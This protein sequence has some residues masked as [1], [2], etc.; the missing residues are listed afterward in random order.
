MGAYIDFNNH[1]HISM[2][3]NG[4]GVLRYIGYEDIDDEFIQTLSANKKVRWVQISEYLPDEAYSA[5]DRIFE[6]RPDMTFRLFHF[7]DCEKLDI[8]FLLTMPHMHRLQID[9]ITGLR[10]NP[11]KI[12][13]NILEKL[14]LKSLSLNC[15]GLRDYYFIKNLSEGLEELTIYADVPSG[16]IKYDNEWLLRYRNLN[17][18]W[19][20]K[21]AN[22]HFESL[23]ELSSLR[24]LSLRGIKI[25]DFSFLKKMNL[26]KISLLWNSNNDLHELA[27]LT[28]LKEIELWRINKLDDISFIE[29]LTDLEVIKLQDLKHIKML[30][31]LSRHM[32]LKH[33]YLIDTGIDEET[34]PGRIR[35]IVEHWDNR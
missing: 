33:I 22:K 4:N 2:E 12:D 26:E 34:L 19:I 20:G 27:E 1:I 7:F 6:A 24:S 3:N 30:P 15:F 10:D 28:G 31:N 23:Y 16:S 11:D 17:T 13:F 25:K 9:S 35:E 8:S 21:K 18:L 29:S 14:P 32:N 5:I